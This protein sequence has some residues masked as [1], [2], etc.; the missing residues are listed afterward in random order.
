M[1]PVEKWCRKKPSINHLRTF[2]CV[3]WAHI[4]N[5]YRKKLD[6]KSYACIMMGYY[7][8]SY[9]LFDLV[10]QHIM[11]RRNVIFDEKTLGIKLSNSSSSLLHNY[12]FDIVASNGSILP[13][14]GVLTNQS[15]F[16]LESTDSWSTP[17]ET[18]TSPN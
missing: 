17:I 6:A 3:A 13:C 10:K 4:S 11:I 9:Q 15:T 14:F 1:T 8:K 12:P 5:D 7:S 18:V 2:G 16:G